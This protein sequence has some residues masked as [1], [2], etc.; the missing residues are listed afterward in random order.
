MIV[1]RI[2][3]RRDEKRPVLK[4]KLKII[5]K[6]KKKEEPVALVASGDRAERELS[7]GEKMRKDK[8]RRTTLQL[9]GRSGAFGWP[10]DLFSVRSSSTFQRQFEIQS[11]RESE[12]E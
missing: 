1:P 3:K 12:R 2:N 4:K 5:I 10:S 6:S 8:R 11:E 9:A 7:E